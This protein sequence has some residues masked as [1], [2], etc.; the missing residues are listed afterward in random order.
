MK[1]LDA[2]KFL[3]CM[4]VCVVVSTFACLKYVDRRDDET[5][6]NLFEVVAKAFNPVCY[7]LDKR[8]YVYTASDHAVFRAAKRLN[9]TERPE[10]ERMLVYTAILLENPRRNVGDIALQTV[11]SKNENAEFIDKLVEFWKSRI[12]T[13]TEVELCLKHP[14]RRLFEGVAILASKGQDD[15]IKC[16]HAINSVFA[17]PN[18]SISPEQAQ[19]LMTAL[20]SI[21]GGSD[22]D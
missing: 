19:E 1:A 9:I 21:F 15:Y 5:S 11:I 2:V 14:G 17:G 7:S 8:D 12:T 16:I 6:V 10:E 4:I 18:D 20:E 3:S 22:S 13:L